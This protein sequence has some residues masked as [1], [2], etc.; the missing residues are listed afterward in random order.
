MFPITRSV[1]FVI[2]LFAAS[3]DVLAQSNR[4]FTINTSK[5]RPLAMGGAFTAVVDVLAAMDFNPAAYYLAKDDDLPPVTLFLNPV[6]PFVG[7]IH[8]DDL[9]SGSGSPVDDFLLGLSLVLKSMSFNFDAVQVGFNLS[10]EGLNLPEIFFENN[11]V[12]VDGFR[13]NHSHTV[14]GRLELAKK[15]SM[16]AAVYFLFGSSP[17][18]PLKRVKDFGISYGILLRPEKGLNIGVSFVDP[19]D[20]LSQYRLPL[21]RL[22]NESVN[23][24]V[25]YEL[26]FTRTLFSIDVRNLGEESNVAVRELHFGIEQVL[27]SHLALRAGYFKKVHGDHVFSWG[28]G[29]LNDS[30]LSS[31]AGEG[32]RNFYLNYA[33]VHEKAL[34]TDNRWHLFS[35][36]IRI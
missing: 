32:S 10:E 15:V 4:Y 22:V 6:S 8:H 13:Q 16:G 23:I 31:S 33:F 36:L 2:V 27:L 20:S 9:F 35:F 19:P 34:P 28:L 5:A 29:L 3:L 26:L 1:I 24:G 30:L 17:L 7:G 11:P 14:V 21:E 12:R 25:S 18:A